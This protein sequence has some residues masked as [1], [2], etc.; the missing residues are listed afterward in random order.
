MKNIIMAIAI[1]SN[2]FMGAWLYGIYKGEVVITAMDWGTEI[3]AKPVRLTS[4]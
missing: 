2:L 3:S 1:T 4:K